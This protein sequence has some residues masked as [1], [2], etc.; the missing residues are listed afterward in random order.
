M[1]TSTTDI[2]VIGAGPA[3]AVAA[4]YLNKQGHKVLVL[5]KQVF[6]RF[7]IGE[8]LLPQCMD[9]LDAVGFLPAVEGYGFQKKTGAAF[10]RGE[11]RCDF[12]FSE[13]FTKGW[14]WTWQVQR[15]DFDN[16][17]IQEAAK[18]GVTVEFEAEVTAVTCS[19]TEQTV[20][21]KD[22]TGAEHS[23]TAKYVVD[24]SGYGRVLPRLFDLD[25]PA[26]STAR[27]SVFAHVEEPERTEEANNNIFI[28][29]FNDNKAWMWAIPFSN[30]TTSVGIVGEKEYVEGMAADGGAKYKEFIST[31]PELKGRFTNSK[32]VFQPRAI[33]GYSVGVKQMYGDGFVMCGNS[34]EFLD[35]VFS[36][37]VTLATSSGLMAAQL[38]HKQLSGEVVDWDVEY[39]A[40]MKHGVNVFRSYVDGWYNGDLQT[41]FFADEIEQN[42]K[43]Q[44][45]SVLAGYVWDETN[46]FV[47]KHDKLIGTLAR[48][49]KMKEQV[50][51]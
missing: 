43:D 4:A 10:Y 39:E 46:P 3:G 31:T 8:S 7:V 44:I 18:Q 12:Y 35:P 21:Y 19:P 17:L 33:L 2:I 34:T 42:I 47:K 49:I 22:K 36:S 6:P 50:T 48:V 15:K 25:K 30:S 9:Q 26:T 23:V 16:I 37:G 38:V 28:H 32:L 27:G 41:I 13:Q 29:S 24:A 14:T 51:T 40:K 20:S 1:G 45:C 11:K 5:E